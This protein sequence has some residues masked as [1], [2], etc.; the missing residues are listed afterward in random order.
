MKD[1]IVTRY[2]I[3]TI[4]IFFVHFCRSG[5]HVFTILLLICQLWKDFKLQGVY[6]SVLMKCFNLSI[7][8]VK[9]KIIRQLLGSY[10]TVIRDLL[11]SYQS[12][13][14]QLSDSYQTV[15][16]QLLDSYQTVIRQLLDSYQKTSRLFQQIFK[17]NV[18]MNCMRS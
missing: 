2:T 8:H 1:S 18:V 16:R 5:C 4:S 17:P 13:I 3:I 9:I 11:E 14:R 15:I 7:Y 6:G 12:V 10:Q